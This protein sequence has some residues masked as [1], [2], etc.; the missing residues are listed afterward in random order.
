MGGLVT[1]TSGFVKNE[2]TSRSYSVLNKLDFD[3]SYKTVAKFILAFLCSQNPSISIV[4]GPPHQRP[5]SILSKA[6]EFFYFSLVFFFSLK[7]S[8][9]FSFTSAGHLVHTLITLSKFFLRNI[10]QL[11]F[12]YFSNKKWNFYCILLFPFSMYTNIDF[13]SITK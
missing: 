4:K 10:L 1:N 13:S 3:N 5:L 7:K 6:R 9:K 8:R 11:T 2:R 12:V